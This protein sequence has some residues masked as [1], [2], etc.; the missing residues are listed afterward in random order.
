MP[1][2]VNNGVKIHYEVEGEGSPLVLIHGLTGNLEDWYKNGFVD[3]LKDTYQHILVDLRDHGSS[4][5]PHE[6]VAY[7][8]ETLASDIT[9]V[10]DDLDIEKTHVYGYSMGGRIVYGL[11]K[12][13]ADRFHSF[14]IGGAP[15][16]KL[17]HSVHDSFLQ[18][19]KAGPEKLIEFFEKRSGKKMPAEEREIIRGLDLEAIAAFWVASDISIEDF[20]PDF[21][22]PCLLFGGEEDV[23]FADIKKYSNLIPNVTFFSVPGHGHGIP[24]EKVLPH[25]I[26]FLK[27]LDIK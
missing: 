26:K 6:I 16:N 5:K 4:D 13:C 20:L 12:Y 2:A 7:K 10:L 15:P 11:A 9:A 19:F 3:S 18:I 14:I 1:F 8:L 27:S 23:I 22:L 17:E 24:K 25:I 21:T